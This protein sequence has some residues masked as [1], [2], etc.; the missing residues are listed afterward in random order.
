MRNLKL[1][2][3]SERIMNKSKVESKVEIIE[4][5]L[6]NAKLQNLVGSA[7]TEGFSLRHTV[8]MY[9]QRWA[10]ATNLFKTTTRYP[11]SWAPFGACIFGSTTCASK[12]SALWS[13][14]HF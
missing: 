1:L 7:I 8:V 5:K 4:T 9:T 14:R 3:F 2:A 6:S 13:G 12:I 10:W 11:P